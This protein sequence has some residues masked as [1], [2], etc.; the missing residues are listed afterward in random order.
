M[1]A[2]LNAPEL[3][4]DSG[5]A[6]LRRR[7]ENRTRWWQDYDGLVD[8]IRHL[9]ADRGAD[10]SGFLRP[11]R[12]SD[13]RP[14]AAD[15][16]VVM[17]NASE[18]R[19][20]AIIVTAHAEPVTVELPGLQPDDV[21][22][23]AQAMLA[24]A[25]GEDPARL[26]REVLTPMLAWLWDVIVAEVL[27]AIPELLGPAGEPPRVWWL[28]IGLLGLLPIHAAGHP[29][30]VSAL[31]KMISSYIPTLRSLAYSRAR[32]GDFGPQPADRR[33]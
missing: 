28:P 26:T 8:Q 9:Q 13:L 5:E 19:S 18:L 12:L 25:T 6:D 33:A 7:I 22:T 20:D 31:E 27:A 2:H 23:S 15:G 1:R 4:A 14:A 21:R 3:P 17:V 10:F 29:D 24:F 11:P 32:A 30:Q 16:A